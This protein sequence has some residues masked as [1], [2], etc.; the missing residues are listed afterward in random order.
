MW[1][2]NVH[3]WQTTPINL[4]FYAKNVLRDFYMPSTVLGAKAL[5]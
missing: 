5:N 3:P 1:I 2:P 4:L